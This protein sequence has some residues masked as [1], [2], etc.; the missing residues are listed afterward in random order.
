V[1]NLRV[2]NRLLLGKM[3]TSSMTVGQELLQVIA[4]IDEFKGQGGVVAYGPER[5]LA[6]SCYSQKN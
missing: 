5:G 2:A 6:A 4:E 1:P 3:R